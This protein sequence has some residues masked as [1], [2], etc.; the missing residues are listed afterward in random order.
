ML[1][2]EAVNTAALRLYERLGFVVHHSNA[3]YT[4]ARR[5]DGTDG[6][7]GPATNPDPETTS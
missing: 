5:H 4:P 3:A 2:V 7:A 6:T 1:Y